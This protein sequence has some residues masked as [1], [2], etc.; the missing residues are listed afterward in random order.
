MEDVASMEGVVIMED[1]DIPITQYKN[2][3]FVKI[4]FIYFDIKWIIICWEIKDIF[5]WFR[6]SMD[7]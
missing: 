7:Y 1:D 3:I 5:A 2:V 4:C 6:H